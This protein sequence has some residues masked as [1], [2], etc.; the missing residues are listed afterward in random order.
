M[1]AD[2]SNQYP[3]EPAIDVPW[4]DVVGFLRQLSHDLR[5]Q[6][7]AVELQSAF[8]TELATDAEMKEEIKRLRQMIS[9]CATNLQKITT[10][11]G[12]VS[13]NLSPYRAK[14]LVEDIRLK[15]T[16]EF[17]DLAAK[18]EWDVLG[19]D[20][21]INIDP[22]L[23]QEA[24]LEL[25]QN[26]FQQPDGATSLLFIAR[27]ENGRLFLGLHEPKTTF[28]LPTE[29]W[30]REPLRRIHRGH[31]GL[32]LNR[33]RGIIEAHG[34]KLDAEYDPKGAKLVTRIS[35]PLWGGQR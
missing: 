5:N 22:Q 7:N 35:L 11:V 21:Q 26:A 1:A 19:D 6:L 34:G 8:L 18:V 13:L 24:L 14:D 17:P 29:N 4:S 30:G 16:K 28:D 33:A 3:I 2:E 10:R 12:A 27:T 15:L 9:K 23:L 32:G 25:F 20:A 31:Y